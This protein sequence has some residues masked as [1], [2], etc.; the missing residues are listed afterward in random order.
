MDVELTIDPT[1]AALGAELQFTTVD[2]ALKHKVGPGITSNPH[3]F[4]IAAGGYICEVAH[5]GRFT[6]AGPSRFFFLAEQRAALAI[7]FWLTA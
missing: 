2:G 6:H 1:R 4:S 3:V 5:G 7:E